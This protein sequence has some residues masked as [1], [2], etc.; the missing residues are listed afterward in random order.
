M[1][2]R[3]VP[4]QIGEMQCSPE[5]LRATLPSSPIDNVP[6]SRSQTD[7][8]S[9]CEMEPL[10]GNLP[11]MI[12]LS[13]LEQLEAKLDNLQNTLEDVPSRVAGLM[14]QIWKAK[15][16]DH[17]EN[18]AVSLERVS[19]VMVRDCPLSRSPPINLSVRAKEVNQCLQSTSPPGPDPQPNQCLQPLSPHGHEP[20]QS[21]C[22]QPL[23][24]TGPGPRQDCTGSRCPPPDA[25]VIPGLPPVFDDGHE[26]QQDH[27]MQ[28][29]PEE[30]MKKEP[31]YADSWGAQQNVCLQPQFH[32]GH[33]LQQNQC[34][35]PVLPDGEEPSEFLKQELLWFD[36]DGQRQNLCRL[37][38][39]QE[40]Q[41]LQLNT[42]LQVLSG[43]HEPHQNC[44]TEPMHLEALS[45]DRGYKL[46]PLSPEDYDQNYKQEPLHPENRDENSDLQPTCAD[47]QGPSGVSSFL[48]QNAPDTDGAIARDPVE[49]GNTD[50]DGLLLNTIPEHDVLQFGLSFC[51]SANF[52][53]S[54]ERVNLFKFTRKL[55]LQK[56]NKLKVKNT[57]NIAPSVTPAKETIEEVET[58]IAMRDLEFGTPDNTPNDAASL[59]YRTD[60]NCPNHF[61][62]K[63]TFNPT[64]PACSIDTFETLVINDFKDLAKRKCWSN[65]NLTKA[66]RSAIKSLENDPSIVIRQSDKGGNVVLMD[67]G[68]YINEGMKQLNV[69]ECYEVSSLQAI[70]Q[71]NIAYYEMLK[72]W[73]ESGIIEWDEYSFLLNRNPRVAVLYLLP[74]LHKDPV[75]PPGRPIVSSIGSLL[76][77]TLRYIDFF[78]RS[79]VENVPSYL[80]DSRDFI[81]KV[82]NFEWKE[83]Y[84][85]ITL[86]V[87]SLYTSIK[88]EDGI[89]ACR[90]FLSSRSISYLKHSDMIV[91]MMRFCLENNFFVFDDVYYKQRQG[92]AMGTCFAPSFANLFM[93]SW[94]QQVEKTHEMY[95]SLVKLWLRYIDDLFIIWEGTQSEAESFVVGLNNNDQ[96]IKLEGHMDTQSMVFL[97]LHVKVSEKKLVTSLYRKETAGN[98]LLHA[99]SGHPRA[100]IK[101]IPF[102]EFLRARRNCSTEEDFVVES[103]CMGKRFIDRGYQPSIIE[104]ARKKASEISH[105]SLL[106]SSE[107]L[108]PGNTKEVVRFISTYHSK[109]W[110]VLNIF[111]CHWNVLK[112]EPTLN[113]VLPENPKV[114]YR[115]AHSL[116]DRLSKNERNQTCKI[117]HTFKVCE[118]NTSTLSAILAHQEMQSWDVDKYIPD[119][120]T[121]TKKEESYTCSES[122]S[123]SSQLQLHQ[124]TY[125]GQK[126]FK[127]SE[128]VKSFSTLSELQIHQRTHTGEKPFKCSECAKCFRHLSTLQTHQRMHTGEKPFKCS[129]CGKSFSRLSGLHIHQ[130]THTGEKPYHCSECD[131][132]FSYSSALR[133]HQR[134]HTGEKPFKCNECGKSCGQLSDL[135][136]HQRTHTGEK[137]F[138]CSEC[139]SSFH[140]SSALRYHQGTH[141]GEKPFKC[142]KCVKSFSHL[143]N[144]QTHQRIHTGEKP[145]KCS[146]CAKCF[147]RL[148]NLQTHQQTHTGEKPFKCSECVKSFSQLSELQ[149]HQR[150]HTGEKPYHC[151]EC[152]SA[153]IDSSPL[154]IHQRIHTGEKTFKC[155]ECAMYF[156]HLSSLQRHNQ[157]HTGE[158]PFNC[159]ECGKRFSQLSVLKSHQRTHTGNKPYHC[160]ECESS[161]SYS[162]ALRYHQQTHT[163]EKPFKCNECGKSFSQLSDLQRH[164]RI[165]K[166][167]K[168]IKCNEYGKSF[169]QLSDLQRHQRIHTGEKPYDCCECLK[170]FSRLST[171]RKH[172]QTHTGGKPLKCNE[173]GKSFSLL[174]ELQ[175]HQQTHRGKTY[176][177]T[178]SE[179]GFCQFSIPHS[180]Q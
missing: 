154:R 124:Q 66:E 162:S 82:S 26:P 32:K 96:N 22:P 58:L 72:N 176:K 87:C 3:Q 160:S 21:Q 93:A 31:L 99:E 108:K 16:L 44:K 69:K 29:E 34:R 75:T 103:V 55:R 20:K 116:K 33:E 17:L 106:V 36:G 152:D 97:D 167:E 43:A 12:L 30:H 135:K 178:E 105:Q 179:K 159:S 149:I 4:R 101:S 50:A 171:L 64:L 10:S 141:T 168:P 38:A 126:P 92:T 94:E 63:S 65:D 35:Q 112:T 60:L 28:Q 132:S 134:T 151:S 170:S 59:G 157:T 165:H 175:S 173:C 146:E 174:L 78:L 109:S 1:E 144:L 142:N 18:G 45:P 70:E 117:P 8:Q 150:T 155:S 24:P 163:G 54:Q 5:P 122:F 71:S 62:S 156:R 46:E 81:N 7:A 84:L 85:L 83:G 113:E 9:D 131:S 42:C 143:S 52:N 121:V 47:A 120:Q 61:K 115:K 104:A 2:K 77:N 114:T 110:Q 49:K 128:C 90:K 13:M 125:T 164:Q 139:D 140:S 88:H 172:Q 39:F 123:L 111:K 86:D 37:P 53:Y 73:R 133:S 98:T 169:S 158:K 6:S 107:V 100:L 41:S 148:S 11:N 15:G 127:C 74:K 80:R 40:N 89:K 118:K 102:G 119:P 137:P 51:P 177:G 14:E 91:Q 19:P 180:P 147:N 130:R 76:E 129:E 68:N 145:F 27:C 25:Q 48:A 56:W 95:R 153:F 166:G 136:S 161:F 138:H 57:A 23:S 67:A 79:F